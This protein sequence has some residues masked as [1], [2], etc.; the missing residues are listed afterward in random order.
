MLRLKVRR[1]YISSGYI[2]S[3]SFNVGDQHKLTLDI[4][5][6]HCFWLHIRLLLQRFYRRRG[7]HYLDG[8]RNPTSPRQDHRYRPRGSECLEC[9]L[10]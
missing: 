2:N 9:K 10:Q 3:I 4:S 7:I 1:F 8:D 6:W 5:S